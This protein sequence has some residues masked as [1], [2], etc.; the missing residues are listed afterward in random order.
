MQGALKAEAQ[1]QR[2]PKAKPPTGG[3]LDPLGNIADSPDAG[4][5][6]TKVNLFYFKLGDIIEEA[7]CRLFWAVV[8]TDVCT[9]RATSRCHIV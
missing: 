3:V 8:F 9:K 4:E 7:F 1:K 2:N 5:D 6:R